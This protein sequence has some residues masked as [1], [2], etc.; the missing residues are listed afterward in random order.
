MST[1][2]K[3]KLTKAKQDKW[4][5]E[6]IDDKKKNTVKTLNQLDNGKELLS[7]LA[8]RQIWVRRDQNG[9]LEEGVR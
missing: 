9:K 2:Q 7:C 1:Q 4:T 5:L 3:E 6:K 8:G